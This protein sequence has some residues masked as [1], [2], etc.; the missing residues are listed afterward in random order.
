MNR[1]AAPPHGLSVASSPART[2]PQR[3]NLAGRRLQNAF[4]S[5]LFPALQAAHDAIRYCAKRL[6]PFSR[7]RDDLTGPPVRTVIT[8]HGCTSFLGSYP[9]QESFQNVGETFQHYGTGD[10][11]AG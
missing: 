1:T 9:S 6:K 11:R 3:R 2:T 10:A 5:F 8:L 4:R 7:K